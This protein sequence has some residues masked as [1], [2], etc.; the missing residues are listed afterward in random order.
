[1][2]YPCPRTTVSR[3]AKLDWNKHH[4]RQVTLEFRTCRFSV[5]STAVLGLKTERGESSLVPCAPIRYQTGQATRAGI[6]WL[7][8]SEL[9]WSHIADK[10]CYLHA[11]LGCSLEVNYLC[12]SSQVLLYKSMTYRC[13]LDISMAQFLGRKSLIYLGNIVVGGTGIEPVASTV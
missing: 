10:L 9:A 3:V 6:R 4:L 13:A 11:V 7:W 12:H 1:V 2:S 5:A 8:R